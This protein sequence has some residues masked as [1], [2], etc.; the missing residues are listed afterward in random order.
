M[1]KKYMRVVVLQGKDVGSLTR[2]FASAEIV[3]SANGDVL[4]NAYGSRGQ[5]VPKSVFKAGDIVENTRTEELGVIP[6]RFTSC[7]LEHF[8]MMP[9][10]G[11][12]VQVIRLCDGFAKEWPRA[13]VRVVHG[14]IHID[15]GENDF[16]GPVPIWG[17]IGKDQ[18]VPY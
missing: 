17:P 1:V 11:D 13:I 6:S 2:D 4:K 14:Y 9:V 16:S 15:R 8:D 3:I 10:S 12:N 7:A 18:T 5:P